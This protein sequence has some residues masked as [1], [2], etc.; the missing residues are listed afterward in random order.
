MIQKLKPYHYSNPEYFESEI[1]QVFDANWQFVCM[2]SEIP[3]QYSFATV[4]FFGKQYFAVNIDNEI[5][6][7]Q[8]V[9]SHRSNKIYTEDF[10]KRPVMCL[11]HSWVY[12]KD[13][14]PVNAFVK[15]FIEDVPA[16]ELKLTEYE[17]A[18][19]GDFVFANFG[20][21][22]ISLKDQLGFFYDE[23]E[24]FSE[25]LGHKIE[26]VT[27][28]NQANWK[29]LIENVLECY[30]CSTVHKESLFS[31]FGMG[32]KSLEDVKI[33]NGSSSFEIPFLPNK[34]S[35]RRDKILR[36]LEDRK[37]KHGSFYHIF[38]FPNLFIT[39]TEGLSFYVAQLQPV[40]FDKS[41]LK[42]R[43]FEPKVEGID[44]HRNLQDMVNQ[45]IVNFGSQVIEEDRLIIENVQKSLGIH[46]KNLYLNKEEIRIQAFHEQ[47]C[48]QIDTHEFHQ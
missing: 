40:A 18:T 10:G 33:F 47:Y 14:A 17:I 34:D 24:T 11:Y 32:R 41:V 13:G 46:N 5:K 37:K 43:Y 35:K 29:L 1:K 26:N 4:D 16:D 48:S 19:V 20:L 28:V 9:C 31:K 36:Y 44:N 6:C 12:D 7:F 22:T 3:E 8:N 15:E 23:L 38:I 39:S 21:C 42:A 25:F 2:K 30:H 27:M 45:D